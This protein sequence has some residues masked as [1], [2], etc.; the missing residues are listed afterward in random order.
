MMGWLA[1]WPAEEVNGYIFT[2]HALYN[3]LDI[4][5]NYKQRL[6]DLTGAVYPAELLSEL[7]KF[8]YRPEDIK[9]E[10]LS[11]FVNV[12]SDS[13]WEEFRI[14]DTYEYIDVAYE[15]SMFKFSYP[16]DRTIIEAADYLLKTRPQ[17]D[18]WTIYLQGMDSMSHQY[19]K[20]YF[21]ENYDKLLPVNVKRYRDLIV[22][23]YRYMDETVGRICAHLDSNTVV[24]V[25]SDHGFDKLMLPTGH[26]NHILPVEP[27]ETEDFHITKS[28]PGIFLAAGPGI[29]SG[30]KVGEICVLDIA[31][32]ILAAMGLPYAEDFDGR[33]A[34]EIF[35]EAA[36]ADTIATYDRF[37]RGSRSVMSSGVDKAV[38]DKLKALGYVK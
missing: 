13:F 14:L 18:F 6:G 5:T 25:V 19:L 8:T 21:S 36:P 23:Y 29:K 26:Y 4:L 3:K 9:R 27:G 12:E 33:I 34:G 7:Q 30:Y 22:N 35:T 38:R 16:G 10:D 31:P 24:V 32:T 1:S 15:A 37:V 11:R 17:P 28:H 20:Y 2:D